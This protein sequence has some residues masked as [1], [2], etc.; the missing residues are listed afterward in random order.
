M[1][2]GE[3]SSSVPSEAGSGSRDTAGVE[4]GPGSVHPALKLPAFSWLIPACVLGWGVFWLLQEMLRRIR[5][6]A[7]WS[8][9]RASA[10]II[11]FSHLVCVSPDQS[12]GVCKVWGPTP[13]LEL[14]F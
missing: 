1:A 3:L 12:F 10:I 8:Y 11:L 2:L 13:Y 5:H 7:L 9:V 14:Y 4:F 6:S